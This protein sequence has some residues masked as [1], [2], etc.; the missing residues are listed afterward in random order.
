M[1]WPPA[2]FSRGI[3]SRAVFSSR[4]VLTATQSGSLSDDTVGRCS[5]GSKAEH[6]SRS[7]ALRV[8]HQPD[9]ALRLDRRLQQQRD[10]L[11]LGPL[12]RVGQRALVGDQLRVGLHDGVEDAQ[13]VGAQRRAGFGGLDDRVGEDRRLDLGGAPRELDVDV[14]A[15]RA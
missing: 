2:A 14:H 1:P 6:V 13:P 10:V 4:M 3:R 5:A 12:P 7:V 8:E 9:A 11:D 15:L